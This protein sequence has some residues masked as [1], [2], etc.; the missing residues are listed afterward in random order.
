MPSFDEHCA[1]SIQLFGEPFG[2]VHKWLDEFAFQPPYGMRHRKK[3]HHQAGIE[4]V[5]KLWGDKAAAAARQHIISD[6]KME[7]WTTGH[8]FP[9]TEQ[10]Y[11]ALGF[12]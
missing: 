7:G 8:P 3:R 5:R 12:F 11:V 1:E 10:E 6:L 2:K 4:E 9:K